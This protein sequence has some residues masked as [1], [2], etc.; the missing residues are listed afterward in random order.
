LFKTLF[1]LL[2][3]VFLTWYGKQKTNN[4]FAPASEILISG[5]RDNLALSLYQRS[6]KKVSLVVIAINALPLLRPG[7]FSFPKRWDLVSGTTSCIDFSFHPNPETWHTITTPS[8]DTT[9]SVHWPIPRQLTDTTIGSVTFKRIYPFSD[10][11]P[12]L[13]IIFSGTS[14][15]LINT[16]DCPV[17]AYDHTNL[18]ET[19]DLLIVAGTDT[20]SVLP[21][22]S[23]FRPRYTVTTSS[24]DSALNKFPNLF[25]FQQ[26]EMKYLVFKTGRNGITLSDSTIFTKNQH[27][28]N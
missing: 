23:I 17:T 25:R 9:F 15:L 13:S 26:Q 3:V 27:N 5:N 16:D 28:G 20:V 19:N 22:R 8:L 10:K 21:Y 11:R 1:L 4:P 6:R 7:Q 14:L 18:K 12:A 2:A 24:P